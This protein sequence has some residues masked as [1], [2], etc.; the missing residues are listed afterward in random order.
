MIIFVGKL[1]D[2]VKENAIFIDGK[3]YFDGKYYGDVV[4]AEDKII[5]VKCNNGNRYMNGQIITIEIIDKKL[6][7]K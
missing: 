6:K 5:Q 7:T 1:D 3:C 4:Y 2:M